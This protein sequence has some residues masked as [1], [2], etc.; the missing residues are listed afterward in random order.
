MRAVSSWGDI[1]RYLKH[2]HNNHNILKHNHNNHNILKL[3]HHV[4][5]KAVSQ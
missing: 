3:N 4:A 5:I 2:S 1:S